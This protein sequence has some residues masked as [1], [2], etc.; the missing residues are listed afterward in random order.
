MNIHALDNIFI[1]RL[2]GGD[3]CLL[4]NLIFT[5]SERI[6]HINADCLEWILLEFELLQKLTY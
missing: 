1:N 3:R 5:L 4:L 6:N 2:T